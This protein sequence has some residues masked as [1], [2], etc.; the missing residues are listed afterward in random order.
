MRRRANGEGSIYKKAN[1]KWQGELPLGLKKNG[2]PDK[3]YFTGD[4]QKDVM[5]KMK[6]A[7]KLHEQGMNLKSKRKRFSEWL[8][9]WHEEYHTVSVSTKTAV[10]NALLMER[11]IKPANIAKMYVDEITTHHIQMFINKLSKEGKIT[12]KGGLSYNSVRLIYN[13]LKSALAQAATNRMI[14][15]NP[16]L[17]IKLPKRKVEETK[18]LTVEE[19]VKFIKEC[20]HYRYGFAAHFCLKT[21][22]RRGELLGLRWT[23]INF[24]KKYISVTQAASRQKPS[25]EEKSTMQV[26]DLKNESSYRIVPLFDELIP[27]LKKHQKEQLKEKVKAGPLYEDNDLVFCNQNGKPAEVSR[28]YRTVQ[29]IGEKAGIE[30]VHP[31]ALRHSYS[32]RL[33]ENGTDPRWI[34]LLLGHSS[35]KMQAV[36]TH[37]TVETLIKVVKEIQKKDFPKTGKSQPYY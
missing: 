23:D 28:F 17:G 24:E 13:V 29:A 8:D 3:K 33:A 31:H 5:D 16:S 1:G 25:L 11:Y 15:Y 34:Q 27:L 6:A 37:A 7:K 9:T 2:S 36:Y 35:I 22:L 30:G 20:S 32:T 26:G 10:D 19:E 12:S 21:G 18:F 4:T 14:A